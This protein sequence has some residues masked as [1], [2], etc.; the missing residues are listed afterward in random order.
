MAEELNELY[1]REAGMKRRSLLNA[2]GVFLAGA[3]AP[4]AEAR[5]KTVYYDSVRS[6]GVIV[7]YCYTAGPDGK[8]VGKPEK[9]AERKLTF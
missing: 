3:K 6:D 2:V 8:T 5:N 7:T 4:A 1:S 9:V